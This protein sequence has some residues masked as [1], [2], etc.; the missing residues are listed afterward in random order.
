MYRNWIKNADVKDITCTKS[1]L[2]EAA[3]YMITLDQN[4]L[5][6]ETKVTLSGRVSYS[7]FIEMNYL[8]LIIIMLSRVITYL[9]NYIEAPIK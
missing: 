6:S 9:A 5:S 3:D 7:S 4:Q 1:N 8:Y 2:Y